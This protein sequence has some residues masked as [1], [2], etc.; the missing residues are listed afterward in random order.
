MAQ[1]GDPTI[2]MDSEGEA[3]QLAKELADEYIQYLTID[4]K[5]QEIQ[6]DDSI[7]ELLTH[8]EEVCAV[9]DSYRGK[10]NDLESIPALIAS[11][12]SSLDELFGQIDRLEQYISETDKMLNQLDS[13]IKEY[14]NQKRSDTNPILQVIDMLPRLNLN[15][16]A[17]W[18]RD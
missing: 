7:E 18:S 17:I 1:A 13:R 5:Q 8:M 15:M 6:V 3:D 11:K 12:R 16:R 14:E 9:L 2:A 10:S 4:T